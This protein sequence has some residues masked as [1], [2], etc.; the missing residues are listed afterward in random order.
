MLVRGWSR[1]S[2]VSGANANDYALYIDINFQVR[3]R[4]ESATDATRGA[5]GGARGGARGSAP[6]GLGRVALRRSDSV[7]YNKHVQEINKTE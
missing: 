6:G 5:Q 4:R 1:A 2:A 7:A 3:E